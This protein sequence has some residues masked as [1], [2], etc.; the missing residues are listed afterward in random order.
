MPSN[1]LA[2]YP[3]N[4]ISTLPEYL[5]FKKPIIAPISLIEDAP[6]AAIISEQIFLVSSSFNCFGRY[7]L[8]TAV[9]PCSISYKSFLLFFL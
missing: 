8:I 3:A 9:S 6:V 2:I 1:S 5:D 7:S 4:P